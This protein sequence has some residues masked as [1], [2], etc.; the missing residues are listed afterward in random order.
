MEKRMSTAAKIDARLFR[1]T[2]GHHPTGVAV[3]TAIATGDKPVGMAV[4]SFSSVSLDPPLVGF[5]PARTSSTFPLIWEAG[6]FCV[7]VLADDQAALGRSF[8]LTGTDRFA[9]VTWSPAPSGAPLID[10]VAAWIDCEIESVSPAGD[11][12]LT[13]G[14]VRDLGG[15][16]ER[17]PLVFVDGGFGSFVEA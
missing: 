3:V 12:Y 7:N 8:S 16:S 9:A 2:L 1:R 10:G 13:L 14:R 4:G 6:A 15:E 11:H 5:F 17:S